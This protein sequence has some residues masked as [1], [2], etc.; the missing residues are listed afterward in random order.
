MRWKVFALI[1]AFISGLAAPAAAHDIPDGQ[2]CRG[3]PAD[4]VE[5]A[6]VEEQ[7]RLAVCVRAHGITVL[8]VGG[9]LWS[10]EQTDGPCGAVIVAD[11]TVISGAGDDWDYDGDDGQPGTDDDEHCD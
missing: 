5:L 10:D 11:E 7:D 9:E 8:Y 1:I 2:D 3:R 4:H 6:T